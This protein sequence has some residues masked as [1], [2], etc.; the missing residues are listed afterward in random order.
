MVADKKK[1]V[2][3]K[4][5]N[6]YRQTSLKRVVI[7]PIDRAESGRVVSQW[8]VHLSSCIEGQS[9]C[10]KAV[11][12]CDSERPLVA[13]TDPPNIDTSGSTIIQNI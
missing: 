7:F 8:R 2:M 3:Q 11:Y 5:I 13:L 4:L 12:L 9:E 1:G 6:I 10:N